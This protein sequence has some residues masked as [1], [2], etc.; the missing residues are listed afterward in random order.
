M[1]SSYRVRFVHDGGPVAKDDPKGRPHAC[2]HRHG[3]LLTALRCLKASRTT[4]G[5]ATGLGCG[6]QFRLMAGEPWH[7][8]KNADEKRYAKDY[9]IDVG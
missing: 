8:I 4:C 5:D 9:R 1:R 2:G 6:L 7:W 3:S